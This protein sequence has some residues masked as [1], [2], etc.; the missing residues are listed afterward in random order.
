ML[1]YTEDKK[2]TSKAEIDL[3]LQ[4]GMDSLKS[5]KVYTADEVEA[6]FAREF[7]KR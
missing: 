3:E 1:I 7:G 5:G 2:F 4:K 6:E